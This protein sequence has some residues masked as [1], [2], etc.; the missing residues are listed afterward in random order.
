MVPAACTW[1][2][3]RPTRVV[4]AGASKSRRVVY[5]Q[6][7]NP[8]ILPP[9]Q[10]SAAIFA[11]QG[12]S[13]RFLSI[14]LDGEAERLEVSG[15]AGIQIERLR[16]YGAGW[17]LKLH[18]L[19]FVFWCW[20]R[21]LRIKPALLYVSD[22]ITGPA[23]VFLS[24]VTSIP[25]IYHEHDSPF[26]VPRDRTEKWLT[27]SR[28]FLARRARL[29]VLPN[30]L[31]AEVFTRVAEGSA[32]VWRVMNCPM[33]SEIPRRPASGSLA[34]G[35]FRLYYQGSIVPERVP[36]ALLGALAL[37]PDHVHL[38]LVGF[39]TAG[40]PGYVDDLAAEVSARGLES[41]VTLVGLVAER[42]EMLHLCS[43]HNL[44]LALLPMRT[45][46]LNLRA[47]AGASNKI[48]EYFACGLPVLVSD[49]PDHRE[50][51][52]DAGVAKACNP[53]S[54]ES[55]A[56]AVRWFLDHRS[57]AVEM[58]ARARRRIRE[59]W[60]YEAQFQPVMDFVS[61]ELALAE[62]AAQVSAELTLD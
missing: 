38:S 36:L 7:T 60:N 34:D 10:R 1:L 53:D 3:K 31:R 39:A 57:E 50:L 56:D 16:R 51:F 37:L 32:P 9:I 42:D 22:P 23:G 19:A 20:Y 59:D 61:S 40:R 52:V 55:I 13:V 21:I 58:G 30:R 43:Q 15:L 6:Y 2:P 14:E 45:D 18:Y 26:E 27:W 12:W 33:L 5:V 24:L 8:S 29:C 4:D 62:P 35:R 49:L 47:M 46:Q 41:R 54:A 48:F 17:R 44:G 28:N 25:I 11:S